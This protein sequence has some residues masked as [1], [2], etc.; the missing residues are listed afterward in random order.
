MKILLIDHYV[1]SDRMGMEYRPFYLA[2]EWVAAGHD[3]TLLGAD[4]SHLR[5]CQPA[6]RSDLDATEEEGVR[7]RWL[8][9]NAYQG[10]GVGRMAN[11]MAFVGKLFAHARRIA[12]EERPDIVVCSS[13][14]PLDIYPGA[15]IARMAGARLVF[16]MHDLWPL[17]PILLGGYAPR[18]PYIRLLQHAEDFAYRHVDMVISLLPDAH[19]HMVA[20]GLDP[21]RFAHIPNGI[22]VAHVDAAHRGSLPDPV[23]ALIDAERQAGRFL[24]GFAGGLNMNM[25]VE[26]MQD[27]AGLLA[28]TDISF[29][30][31]GDGSRGAF[32]RERAQ[33]AGLRHFHMLGR[34]PK[35]A[36]PEFLSRMDVL[37]IPWHRNPLYRYGVS[38][39]KVFDYMLAGL[40]ILQSSEASNDLVAEGECGITVPAEDAAA[41]AAAASRLRAMP[42]QERRRLGENG[43]R[44]VLENH[45]FRV[46][47]SR[48]LEAVVRSSPRSHRVVRT[49]APGRAVV[50]GADAVTGR[51][52]GIAT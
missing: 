12:R 2:R 14:Y 9:T 11:M 17:T 5:G 50:S 40:P 34:I 13:T 36:V 49:P 15:W 29:V 8:R 28:G 6:V 27:A 33:Q 21:D 44:F 10:N 51:G 18:H 45:D 37:A 24:I 46:L 47:A 48:F 22:P 31:V 30:V 42:P 7:F 20:H 43:R 41:F 26:T 32:L 35:A 1:G 3:V 25:A 16:E 4:F 52:Q 23:A 38:P 19:D 39:N